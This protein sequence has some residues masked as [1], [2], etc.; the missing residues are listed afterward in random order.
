MLKYN[1]ILVQGTIISPLPFHEDTEG[2]G[3]ITPQFFTLA[4]DGDGGQLNIQYSVPSLLLGKE[5]SVP[6]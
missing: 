4:L 1:T 6:I 3:A 5:L 2:S